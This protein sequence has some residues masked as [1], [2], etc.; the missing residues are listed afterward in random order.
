[1][2]IAE[3]RAAFAAR[4]RQYDI[5]ILSEKSIAYGIQW[6]VSRQNETAT[7]NTYHGKKGFR[8]VVQG[9]PEPL[10]GL[11]MQAW[12][13]PAVGTAE[14]KKTFAE[15]GEI[16]KLRGRIVGCD[17]SGKGDVLGPLS[18][19]AVSLSGEEGAEVAAWGVCD[20]KQLTDAKI[21]LLADRFLTRF[22]EASVV[23]TLLPAEYNEIYA[24]Y[25]QANKN[26]NHLLTDIHFHNME[27]LCRRFPTERVILDRF[28]PGRMMEEEFARHQ[29]EIPLVQVP[30]GERF[31]EVAAASVLARAAFVRT[32]DALSQKYGIDLP[33][34]AGS[35]VS[36]CIARL[37]DTYGKDVLAEIGKLH[38]K[39]FDS[40]R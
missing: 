34:G 13:G 10:H 32:M 33:K 25:R 4:L 17:E 14:Q 15:G 22:P 7:V 11:I 3:Q 6:K 27:I 31:I 16:E 21:L 5:I 26:L 9:A 40:Y 30:R 38:F 29:L 39:T 28:A 12:D 8:I 19:A 36:S 37:V 24:A 23:T 20:S 1:M 2:D 18:V 35:G